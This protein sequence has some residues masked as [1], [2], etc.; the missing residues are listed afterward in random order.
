MSMPCKINLLNQMVTFITDGSTHI[1][2]PLNI[3]QASSQTTET[4]KMTSPYM[5]LNKMLSHSS[6]KMELWYSGMPAFTKNVALFYGRM[7]VIFFSPVSVKRV[8]KSLNF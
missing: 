3:K 4:V 6:A 2:V 1:S 8:K 7:C 5:Q